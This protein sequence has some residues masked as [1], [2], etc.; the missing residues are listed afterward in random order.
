MQDTKSSAPSRDTNTPQPVCLADS[1]C[2]SSSTGVHRYYLTSKSVQVKYSVFCAPTISVPIT[3]R[4]HP[5][6]VLLQRISQKRNHIVLHT[7]RRRMYRIVLRTRDPAGRRTGSDPGEP[8]ENKIGNWSA[9]SAS[10]HV[11]QFMPLSYSVNISDFCF[12]LPCH[13][14]KPRKLLTS[15]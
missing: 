4:S 3:Y 14:I 12:T 2:L 6:F 1:R 5:S 15:R 11:Q 13:P 9:G 8:G 7:R 10:W